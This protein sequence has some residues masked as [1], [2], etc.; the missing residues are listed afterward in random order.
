LIKDRCVTRGP[1]ART[2]SMGAKIERVSSNLDKFEMLVAQI[3]RG[4]ACNGA[5]FRRRKDGKHIG[6]FEVLGEVNT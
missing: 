1:S 4:P 2:S 5:G 3:S 6:V